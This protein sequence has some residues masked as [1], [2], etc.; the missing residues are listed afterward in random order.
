MLYRKL[1]ETR[2]KIELQEN[3][4]KGVLNDIESQTTKRLGKPLFRN[5]S[6]KSFKEVAGLNSSVPDKTISLN[7]K[8]N[9]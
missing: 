1:H 3:Y 7:V 6:T 4:I 8:L 2:K 9:M 5:Q